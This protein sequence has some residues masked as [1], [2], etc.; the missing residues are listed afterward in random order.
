MANE[1]PSFLHK[2]FASFRRKAGVFFARAYLF[3]RPAQMQRYILGQF[4]SAFFI[5]LF[6]SISLFI[7]FE[8]FERM[9]VFLKE[10]ASFNQVF[11]YMLYK[12]PLVGQLMMPIALLIAT[13]LS[14]GRLSQ[15]SEITA[16]RACG[17][18][19]FFLAR[20]L[21]LVGA[22]MSVMMFINGE[23]LVPLATQK[24]EEIYQFDIKKKVERGAFSRTNFWYRKQNKFYNIGLYDSRT[25][26]LKGISVFELDR[27][28][29]LERR[30]DARDAVWGGSANVGWTMSDVVEI[31]VSRKGDFNTS[32]FERA[33]LIIDEEPSDFY[34]MERSSEA[35]SYR[36]LKRYADKLKA[37]GVPVTNYYVDLAAKTA[38]PL[39]NLIVVLIAFPMALISTRSGNLTTSF[40]AG[41]GIGFGYYLVHAISLSLGN[42][43]LIPIQPA[44]WT[45]NILLGSLGAYFMLG[46]ESKH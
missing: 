10:G 20:P 9:S 26:S 22:F 30:T 33:P 40:I 3:V 34:N 4:L 43:E 46:A 31:A 42:A 38:F 35:M 6:A 21:L 37:E 23:T 14:V 7:V 8:L 28:F 1:A 32:A 27:N 18:S 41:V 2:K 44:A 39:V 17:A 45:A 12:I 11:S 13:L 36:D 19:L 25:A 16:M 5:C 15:V 29:K 24:T